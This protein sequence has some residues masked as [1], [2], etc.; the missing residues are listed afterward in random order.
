MSIENR[1]TTID[2]TRSVH[3]EAQL[4]TVRFQ[5]FGEQCTIRFHARDPLEG[6][7]FVSEAVTWVQS[8]VAKFSRFSPESLTTRINAAA[9]RDWVQVDPEAERM[10]ALAD[11]IFVLTRGILDPTILPLI[12]LWN[13]DRDPP[14]L[15]SRAEVLDA[16]AKTGWGRV[17]RE[18]GRIYLPEAGMGVDF[19]CFAKDFAADRVIEIARAWQIQDIIVDFGHAV[20]TAGSPSNG[21]DWI[22]GI[23]DPQQPGVIFMRLSVGASGIATSGDYR[24]YFEAG[25]RRYGHIIDPRSGYPVSNGCRAVT[26]VANSCLEAGLLATMAYVLGPDEGRARIEE[27]YGAEGCIAC[28]DRIERTRDFDRFVA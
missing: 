17:R 14:R 18:R 22:V 9:G 7:S 12:R 21:A 24:R 11:K 6:N 25:G 2:A 15:P 20:R 5:A 19:G 1:I 16:M 26:V 23:E 28:G 13:Y 10:L 27:F 8:F 4:E 3:D